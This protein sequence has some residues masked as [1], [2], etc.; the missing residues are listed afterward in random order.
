[1]LSVYVPVRN[2]LR[3]QDGNVDEE[4]R[5]QI[6]TKY[7]KCMLESFRDNVQKAEEMRNNLKDE[8][9]KGLIYSNES[10]VNA[11][12]E[13]LDL[14]Q[15]N[16]TYY[17][18]GYLLHTREDHINCVQCMNSLTTTENELPSSFYAAHVTSLKSK[19]FLRFASLG[20]FYTFAKVERI[21]QDHFR[22]S[23]AY[24][25]DSFQQTI[26]EVAQ[27]GLNLPNI[28][29]EKHREQLIPFLIYEYI[30]V[31]Y[32]IEAKRYK[33]EVLHKLKEDQ[34]KLRKLSKA[35]V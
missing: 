6:L 3:V 28:G 9:L 26:R 35:A 31:R 33:N 34:Q 32:H 17:L 24:V 14:V 18:C 15:S 13:A 1:M 7:K 8:L 21:L 4:E 20:T 2:V 29:C 11:T 23:S 30:Q 5:M 22:S 16:A 27:D 10:E 12:P 25:R 19:G